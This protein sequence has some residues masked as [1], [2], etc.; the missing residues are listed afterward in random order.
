MLRISK[1]GTNRVKT[2]LR[3]RMFN[4]ILSLEDKEAEVML[5]KSILF[6]Y[7]RV[8]GVFANTLNTQNACEYSEYE[9][10][11]HSKVFELFEVFKVFRLFR[12]FGQKAL[13]KS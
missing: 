5:E 10:S 11:E 6:E 3:V 9:Y 4:E 8:F 1:L 2:A 7:S 13:A 12:V